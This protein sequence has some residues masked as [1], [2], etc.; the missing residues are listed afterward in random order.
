MR[1]IVFWLFVFFILVFQDT[2]SAWAQNQAEGKKLY[3][4]YCASCHGD[5]G[6]GDGVAAKSLPVK[7]SDHSDGSIMNQL[8]DKFLINFSLILFRMAAIR[9]VSRP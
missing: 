4:N 2:G 3:G 7:L 9:S 5:N 1:K 8:S 6:K